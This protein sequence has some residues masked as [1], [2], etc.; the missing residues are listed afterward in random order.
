M[1]TPAGFLSF[2]RDMVGIAPADLPDA[3]PVIAMAYALAID[4]VNP[5]AAIAP[6]IYDLMVYNLATHT[7]I[8]MAPDN[9][10]STYFSNART[11]LGLGNFMAGL[12]SSSSDQ[13]TSQAL[14]IPDFIKGLSLA[15]LQY[16]KTPW[17]RFYL[18]YAQ[19]FGSAWG[20]S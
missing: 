18:E 12:I 14:A 15:D 9:G 20:I 2:L 16:L 10:T 7:L 1:P 5:Q 3:S 4:L 13:G 6:V 17:G 19:R 11:K 8:C